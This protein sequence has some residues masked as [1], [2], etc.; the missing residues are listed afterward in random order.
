VAIALWKAKV[1]LKAIREQWITEI[2]RLWLIK[3]DDSDYLRKLVDS[4]PRRLKEVIV[5]Q[6]ASTKY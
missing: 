4:M 1:P 6:G 3:M 2:K 5:R